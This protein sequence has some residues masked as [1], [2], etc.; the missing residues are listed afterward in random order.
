VVRWSWHVTMTRRCALQACLT[1]KVGI[2]VRIRSY[3][4]KPLWGDEAETAGKVLDVRNILIWCLHLSC[5]AL[6]N[7]VSAVLFVS[8]D[9]SFAMLGEPSKGQLH[10]YIGI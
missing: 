6:A 8:R 5:S 9:S 10:T 2:L 1:P 4:G 3:W 7:I